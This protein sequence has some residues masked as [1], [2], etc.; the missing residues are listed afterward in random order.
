MPQEEKKFEELFLPYV[1][2]LFSFAYHLTRQEKD[3]EDLVQETLLKAYKAIHTFQRESNPKAWLFSI[4]KNTYINAYRRKKKQPAE[5][6]VDTTAV[7]SEETDLRKEIFDALLDDE[8]TRAIYRL[9]DTYRIPLLLSD[10]EGFSYEE[11]AE[12]LNLPM[13]TIRSRLFRAR[14]ILREH[15]KKYALSRGIKDK[16]SD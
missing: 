5:L 2:S 16:S 13:G 12:I 9:R 10:L 3:A 11:I 7:Y 14:K 15:L 6:D 8:V 1:S 4:L